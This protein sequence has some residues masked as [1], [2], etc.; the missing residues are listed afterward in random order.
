MATTKY[1]AEASL[2]AVTER[3]CF[4]L[5]QTS[6]R[7]VEASL[8]AVG[9]VIPTKL[10]KANLLIEHYLLSDTKIIGL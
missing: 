8:R 4:G 10:G 7:R 1:Q 2:R 3:D 5:F 6:Q 9:E